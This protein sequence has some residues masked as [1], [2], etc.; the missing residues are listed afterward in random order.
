MPGTR[1]AVES[2]PLGPIAALPGSPSLPALA[3]EP[4]WKHQP[5]LWGHAFHPMCSYLGSFPAALAHAFIS[6][7]SRPGDVVVDPFSGRGTVP[8]QACA[9]RRIGVGIDLNPL[10]HLLTEAKIDPPDH[11][12]VDDRLDQLRID[13]TR[14]EAGWTELA[15]GAA[16]DP[17][18]AAVPAP[19]GSGRILEPLAAHVAAAFHTRTLAQLLFLRTALDRKLAAD[20]FLL[21]AAVGILHGAS[22]SYLSTAMPNAFSLAPAYTLR[23][24]ARRVAPAPDRDAFRLLGAKSRRLFRDGRPAQ[25][26][27]ALGGEARDA[28]PHILAALRARGSSERARLVVSSPPY[29]RVLRYGSH[30]WLRLWFLGHDPAAVDRATTPPAGTVPYG[31]WLREV[32]VSLRDILTDDAVVV[33][34]LGD[35]AT[36]RGRTRLTVAALAEQVW[37]LAAE[38][39]GYRL[40]G[41]WAD[42]VAPGRKLTRMWGA[43]AGRA[44]S[45]DRL[46]IL[47][48]TEAGRRRALAGASTPVDWRRPGPPSAPLPAAILAAYAADVPPGRSGLDGSAGADEESGPRPDDQPAAL[49]RAPAAAAPVR[50]GGQP[51]A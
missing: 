17:G 5:R 20:R 43:E 23:W 18:Q 33:L 30:D 25:R 44:T 50:A 12:E 28:G 13:W 24:V 3:V 26:G 11:R 22:V 39:A 35:V 2:E 36:D 14:A 10:A 49:L 8:L 32:L 45:T 15:R 34:V 42:H 27:I 7:Y 51:G 4:D 47:G 38:P 46:L 19:S 1:A 9:E 40:A 41:V 29:L 37:A 6:R 21:A 16:A 31:G 48:A